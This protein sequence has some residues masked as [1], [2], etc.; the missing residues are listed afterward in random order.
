[1]KAPNVKKLI[2][3]AVKNGEVSFS[4]IDDILADE[5][6]FDKN[7]DL[8]L[9]SLGE[10]ILGESEPSGAEEK[11]A[12]SKTG[13]RSRSSSSRSH[14]FGYIRDV[15]RR[16]RMDRAEEIRYSKRLEFLRKR[17]VHSIQGTSLSPELHSLLMRI[18]E[19]P[20]VALGDQVAPFCNEMGECPKGKKGFIKECCSS[21]NRV[22]ADF[23]ERNLALVVN[24]SSQYRT[25]G[26]PQMDLIQEGNAALIRAVEKFDWRKKV[27]FQTYAAYWI[28][29]AVERFI[30]ANKGIVRLPNYL[31]QKMRRFRREGVIS[32]DH[33]SWTVDA[34][35]K[36]FVLPPEVAGRL[37]ESERGHV[38]LDSPPSTSEN[39]SMAG[40]LATT[41]EKSIPEGELSKLKRRLKEALGV[42]SDKEQFIIHHRFGLEGK[43]TK[44][45]D[46]IGQL[47]KVSR[48]RIRQ[49][50]IRALRKLRR[51]A[52]MEELVN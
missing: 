10:T 16:P 42:L 39:G 25:Y 38:S 6:T 1:M 22:R 20:G 49:L 43:E 45:L 26:V 30:S 34:V 23:V 51:P 21:Y 19:C 48:E 3:E 31:Q 4:L 33:G 35:S 40:M 44:T 36:A 28:R 9:K 37:L 17:L 32:A 12:Q 29:Q 50:Q 5:T 24:L 47:L 18:K 11:E 13:R 27:R 14:L 2:S 41:E 46:E 7:V 52:L 8:L 15:N